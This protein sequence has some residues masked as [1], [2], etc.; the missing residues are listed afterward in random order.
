MAEFP[1]EMVIHVSGLK[2]L[3]HPGL[4]VFP[5]VLI[6]T[7]CGFSQ[8]EIPASELVSLSRPRAE[9]ELAQAAIRS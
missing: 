5:K 3:D 9:L 4:F 7:D 6:C 1:A 8:F 2:N